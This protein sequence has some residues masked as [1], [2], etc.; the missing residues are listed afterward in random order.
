MAFKEDFAFGVA[1][2]AYQ[3]E[4]AW[5]E[6]GKGPS[7]WDEFTHNNAVVFDGYNADIA[8][9]HYHRYKEDIALMHELG[10]NAY[11]FS[12][13]WSRVLPNGI[14]EVNEKGVEFYNNL[15]NEMLAKGITPYLTLYH[16][17]LPYAL[18]T[19]KGLLNEDFP[20]WFEEYALLIKNRFGDRVKHFITFNEPICMFGGGFNPQV[21]LPKEWGITT[22][23]KFLAV[24]HMLLAHGKAVKVLKEIPNAKVGISPNGVFAYPKDENNAQ[25]IEVA[26]KEFFSLP[27]DNP[28][29]SETLY[30][31]AIIFGKY[32]KECFTLYKNDMPLI[33][34]GDMEI[35]SEPIDFLAQNIYNGYPVSADKNGN[36]VKARLTQGSPKT[37]IGW[38]VTPEYMYFATKFLHERYNLP[39]IVSEN[40]MANTDLLTLDKKVHDGARSEFILR[41]ISALKKAVKDGVE[42][43]GYFYWTFMDNFEWCHGFAQRFGIVYIDYQTLERIKKDSFY[44]YQQIIRKE[45]GENAKH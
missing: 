35:I 32:P 37:A 14:G 23:E 36:A 17:D 2:A 43:D 27:K 4:G 26:K 12:V 7:H 38:D 9:D 22:K 6:D 19:K 25:D 21:H 40:G 18:K 45:Q 42:I 8:C 34:D 10:V 20:K 15:I 39:L 30:A 24:H 28:F 33:K 29:V 3:I 5:N 41:H 13:A 1:T 31:D 11:R 44:T 16:F